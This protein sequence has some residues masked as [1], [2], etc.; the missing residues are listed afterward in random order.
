MGRGLRICVNQSGD[1]MDQDLLGAEVQ[2]VNKLTVIASDG[3]KDFVSLLQK[4][5]KDDLY[6]RPTKATP[7]YF[8]GKRIKIGS[9]IHTISVDQANAIYFYLVKNGY[10]DEDGHITDK[11]R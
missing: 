2:D 11:Y 8:A 4:E 6:E 10:V 7:E 3:Y 9:E 5:I 1:R